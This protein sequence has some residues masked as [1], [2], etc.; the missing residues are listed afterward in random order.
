MRIS[1]W[2]SDVCSSDLL[3]RAIPGPGEAC[4]RSGQGLALA[5]A[6]DVAGEV[7]VELYVLRSQVEDVGE[8][9]VAAAGVVDRQAGAL[10]TP[11]HEHV[12][13]RGVVGPRQVLGQH[14]D[15][16]LERGRGADLAEASRH[17]GGG[18]RVEGHTHTRTTRA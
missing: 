1:D 10:L 15:H 17:A 13:P 14:D 2:S 8:A 3:A 16:T 9:G 5:V 4:D 11:R 7:A 12:Q 18:G 6:V